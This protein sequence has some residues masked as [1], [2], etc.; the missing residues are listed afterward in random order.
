[1][2]LAL[3]VY[4]VAGFSHW[5]LLDAEG[6]LRWYEALY[7]V[8]LWPIASLLGLGREAKTKFDLWRFTRELKS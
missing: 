8:L 1:M 3:I 4:I 5:W 2:I 7:I 6:P